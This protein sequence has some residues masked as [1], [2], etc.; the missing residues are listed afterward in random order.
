MTN[1]HDIQELIVD[2]SSGTAERHAL[3]AV[4]AKL[5]DSLTREVPFRPEFEARL[6]R[7]LVAGARR[8]LTSWYRRP[9]IWAPS[10]GVA[11][12]AAVLAVGLQVYRGAPLGGSVPHQ[13]PSFN[14]TAVDPPPLT[15]APAPATSFYVNSV[16]V[17]AIVLPDEVTPAGQAAPAPESLT[18]IDMSRGLKVFVLGSMPDMAQFTKIATGLGFTQQ[19]QRN[20]LDYTVAA[21]GRNLS[22]TADGRVSY[23]DL[24]TGQDTGTATDA[25]GAQ[26]VARRFLDTASLPVPDLQPDVAE[27]AAGEQRTFTVIYK[28]RVEGRP[29]ANGRTVITVSDRSRVL[30]ADSYVYAREQD[31]TLHNVITPDAAL[32]EAAKRGGAHFG[33]EIDLVYVRTVTPR[34]VYLQPSWRVFGT[35]DRGARLVRYVPAVAPE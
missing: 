35:G 31:P 4:A 30:K 1:A 33:H 32:A 21:G 23:T 12:A 5:Q 25:A 18:G 24:A 9:A 14:D 6:R 11:A 28:P 27:T 34:T 19:P 26:A 8:T 16:A 7:Q 3:E 10:V 2:E 15:I 20:G 13:T 22:M 29:V 17:P